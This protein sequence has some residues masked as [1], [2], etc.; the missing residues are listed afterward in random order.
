MIEAEGGSEGGGVELEGVK[1]E[2][3]RGGG[4]G[5][6]RG[7]RVPFE[8]EHAGCGEERAVRWERDAGEGGSRHLQEQDGAVTHLGEVCGGRVL[9]LVGADCQ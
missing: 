5:E 4:R 6:A 9:Q 3:A 1:L 8:V 7:G 2:G